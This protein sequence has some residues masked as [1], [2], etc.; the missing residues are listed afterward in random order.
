[1]AKSSRK[2]KNHIT[3]EDNIL[4]L[5][6]ELNEVTDVMRKNLSDIL[7]REENLDILMA[8]SKDLSTVSV[9]FYKKARDNNK[10]CKMI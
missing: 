8:K 5:Q 4:K 9:E 7:K 2:Y 6:S 1:M 3:L 10:C